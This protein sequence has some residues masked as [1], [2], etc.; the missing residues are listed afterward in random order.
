MRLPSDEWRKQLFRLF[1][2]L[3]VLSCAA[4]P[5]SGQEDSK[6]RDLWQKPQ[7]VMDALRIKEGSIVGD[8]GAGGGYF[9]FHLA[10]RVGPKGRVYAEDI[11]EDE[12]KKIRERAE[13]E[14]LSQ[15]VEVLGAK[16]DPKLPAESLDAILIV[17]AYHEMREHDA[18]LG[19]I[20]RALK[21]GGLLGII[22]APAKPGEAREKYLERHRIPEQFVR[23]DAARCGFKFVRQEP[24]F[25][26]PDNDRNYFFLILQ[27]PENRS[28]H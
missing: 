3:A 26:P 20:L 15:V 21:P 28:T 16:D 22:D 4:K 9:T 1:L 6:A 27:K 24:G 7:E 13:K 17:N 14:G 2:L 10:A 18:M 5:L 19:A 8:I 12:V 25:N 23:D 11:L